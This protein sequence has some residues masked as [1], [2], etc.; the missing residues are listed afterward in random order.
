MK[1]EK[2]SSTVILTSY[3]HQSYCAIEVQHP[4]DPRFFCF[5]SPGINFNKISDQE[6]SKSQ[7]AEYSINP[8]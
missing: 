2:S 5:V 8:H 1:V 3:I 7:S 4:Q 6:R